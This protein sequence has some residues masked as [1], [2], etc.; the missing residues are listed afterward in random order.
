MKVVILAGGKGTRL[1]EETGTRPKPMVEIGQ[2]P[3]LWHI[4][5]LFAHYGL[6]DFVIACGY[7]GEMIVDYF[8]NFHLYDSDVTFAL[9]NG[10]MT[11]HN[12]RGPDW[13]VTLAWTGLETQT[14]GRLRRLAGLLDGERFLVTYGDGVANVDVRR[15]VAFHKG[16]RKK[17]TVTAVRPPSRFGTLDLE[18]DRVLHF[19]EK[20]QFAG[21]WI[22]GGFMLFEPG[23]LDLIQG[24]ETVLEREILERLAREKQLMAFKHDGFWQPM[25]NVRE[26]N[27]LE[28]LWQAGNAPWK[29]WK[30]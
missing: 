17:A 9:K 29:V 15:L 25:D 2:R 10:D 13:N 7:R 18:G 3:V 6:N 8:R 4:M 21:E 12:R 5:K 19:D 20:P 14:G 27:L 1:A 11:V 26:R 30:E 28:S 16:H 23:V 22:N 24:D